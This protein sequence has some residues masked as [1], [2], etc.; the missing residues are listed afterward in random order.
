MIQVL[1]CWKGKGDCEPNAEKW[2]GKIVSVA[3][4]LGGGFDANSKAAMLEDKLVQVG[5]AGI[6]LELPKG[7]TFVPI[8]AILYISL[9]EGR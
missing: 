3:L 9:T 1:P 6:M 2:T 4:R 8:S 7:Q 5:E